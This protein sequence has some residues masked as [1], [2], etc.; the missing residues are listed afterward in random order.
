MRALVCGEVELCEDAA[1]MP[2]DSLRAQVQLRGEARVGEALSH[3]G[4]H[5]ALACAESVEWVITAAG[6]PDGGVSRKVD[7]E[8]GGQPS[9]A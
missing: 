4:K 5:V 8:G 7:R 1:H 9:L 2:L 6:E 3:Q